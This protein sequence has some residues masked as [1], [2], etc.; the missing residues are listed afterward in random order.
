LK[1]IFQLIIDT[2]LRFYSTLTSFD[3]VNAAFIS[4]KTQAKQQK[5]DASSYAAF[6]SSSINMLMETITTVSTV[7]PGNWPSDFSRFRSNLSIAKDVCSDIQQKN[8][9][10][11]FN[12][13][14]KIISDNKILQQGTK[15]VL[16]KYLAFG[17]NLASAK[18]SDEV[19]NA[20]EAVALPPG[21]FSV[22]QKSS[23]NISLNGYIGYAW[24]F[25]NK[26]LY[27]NGVYAP[28]GFSFSRSLG[29]KHGGAVS[30]FASVIDVGA[31]ASYR[32]A[33]SPTDTLKQKIRL[34]SIISPSTQLLVE[35]PRTPIALCAGWRMTP[36]LF[37]SGET[38][39]QAVK[40]KNVFNLSVLIDIPIVTI[41]NKPF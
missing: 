39:F 17:A 25:S 4:L 15:E 35:I 12:S 29:K 34:E 28:L 26:S 21:S 18:N 16:V 6:I 36:K 14:I 2:R 11:I 38:T 33:N 19:E 5:P 13:V 7:I 10:G 20:I 41:F 22:K 24:D 23:S 30:I 27:A 9:S 3:K 37:Y 1:E 31:V 8:Y 40:A 32:L